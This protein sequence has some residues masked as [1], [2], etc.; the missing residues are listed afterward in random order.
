MN[1]MD[2]AIDSLNAAGR[3]NPWWVSRGHGDTISSIELG[4]RGFSP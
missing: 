3:F 2:S 4:G 1:N